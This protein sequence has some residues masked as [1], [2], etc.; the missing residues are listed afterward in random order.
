[1]A[2]NFWRS[3]YAWIACFVC[4]ILISF[5]TKPKPESELVGLVYGMSPV[6]KGEAVSWYKRPA[7]LAGLILLITVV[8]NVVFW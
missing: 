8:A 1:M 4:T 7:V 5:F 2:G 3:T 6:P